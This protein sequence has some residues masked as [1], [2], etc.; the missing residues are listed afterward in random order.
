MTG[1]PRLKGI[2]FTNQPANT[3]HTTHDTSGPGDRIPIELIRA[4]AHQLFESRGGESGHALDD[5][6]LAE[7]EIR[8]H[9]GVEPPG[10][11]SAPD[12]H[13]PSRRMFPDPPLLLLT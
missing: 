2:T 1:Y 6:P 12:S 8:H 9:R 13:L 11:A 3:M 4:R 10:H 5:W 7:H